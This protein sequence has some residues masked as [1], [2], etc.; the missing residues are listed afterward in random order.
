MNTK[1]QFRVGIIG[2]GNIVNGGHRP[3]L[4]KLDDVE[5]AAVMDVTPERLALGQE[6]FHLSNENVYRDHQALIDR[7]DIDIVLIT[8]PQQFRA[9]IVHYAIEKGKHILSEKPIAVTP[10]EAARFSAAAK[11]KDVRFGVMHNY[12]FFPEYRIIKQLIDQGEIG[13]LRV[14]TMNYLGVIDFPGAREYQADWRHKTTAGGGVLMD[15]IHAVYLTEW[16]AGEQAIQV[17]AFADAPTYKARHPEVEDL[18]LLQVAFPSSYALINMGWGQG[19]GGVDVSGS[20]GQIR[21][22]NEQYQTSGFN[23]AAELYSVKDW[24]RTDHDLQNAPDYASHIAEAFMSIWRDFVAAVR[25]HRD[26]VAT[27][28]HAHRALEIALAG[29]VSGVTGRTVELPFPADHPVYQQGVHGLKS[30]E[31]WAG[32]RTRQAKIFGL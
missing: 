26:P 13:D 7:E 17:N 4:A 3:A 5:V 25:E 19:V 16:L 15:M 6:W 23:R 28:D 22:R 2:C 30:L 14:L 29:Y 27:A 21:M 31:S 18:I 8:V 24:V 10:A 1:G 20:R 11:A 12:V 32:S 9:G